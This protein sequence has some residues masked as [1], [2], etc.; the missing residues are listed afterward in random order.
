MIRV[1]LA[2]KQTEQKKG[3]TGG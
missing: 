3:K 1:S 2:F